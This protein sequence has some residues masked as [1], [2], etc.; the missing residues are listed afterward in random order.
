MNT[1][2]GVYN[3]IVIYNGAVRVTDNKQLTRLGANFET[4][5]C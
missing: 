3:R 4:N 1:R 2:P 5:A